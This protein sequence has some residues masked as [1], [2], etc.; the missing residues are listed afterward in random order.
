V[1]ESWALFTTSQYG[2]TSQSPKVTACY[3]NL[4]EAQKMLKT[5]STGQIEVDFKKMIDE[6]PD[7]FPQ[8]KASYEKL[9][10]AQ[11]RLDSIPRSSSKEEVDKIQRKVQD[12]FKALVSSIKETIQ[13]SKKELLNVYESEGNPR[14]THC[15]FL[16][17]NPSSEQLILAESLNKGITFKEASFEGITGVSLD[18]KFSDYA[19]A[20]KEMKE[21]LKFFDNGLLGELA[22]D[23][24]AFSK[25]VQGE[26]STIDSLMNAL[27]L[28]FDASADMQTQKGWIREWLEK[29]PNNLIKFIKSITG[30]NQL[31][32]GKNISLEAQD[33]IFIH[34]CFFSMDLYSR[35]P[36]QVTK[37]KF[38]D[39]IK[40]S[41]SNTKFTGA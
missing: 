3:E 33:R 38:F 19:E 35:L 4:L 21:G 37:E 36:P 14:P 40:E 12:K 7:R 2:N 24:I 27:R 16:D 17:D 9:Q 5:I 6:F 28:P 41:I 20:I 13:K 34:T 32:P 23:P 29:D 30:A 31:P 25:K 26:E 11:N 22:S 8:I 18:E 1:Q 39:R 15:V 10:T